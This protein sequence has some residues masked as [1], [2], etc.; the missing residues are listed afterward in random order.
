M[1][2]ARSV[3]SPRASTRKG[4][5]IASTTNGAGRGAKSTARALAWAEAQSAQELELPDKRA[6]E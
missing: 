1:K 2:R 6:S 4:A 5:G 3:V